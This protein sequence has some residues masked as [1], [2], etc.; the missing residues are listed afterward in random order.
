MKEKKAK[1]TL[2]IPLSGFEPSPRPN[3]L[4]RK[5]WGL[6]PLGHVAA[7]KLLSSAIHTVWTLWHRI[8]HEFKDTIEEK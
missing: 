2:Q 7:T 3:F 6:R 1:K 5:K 4:Q 8:S